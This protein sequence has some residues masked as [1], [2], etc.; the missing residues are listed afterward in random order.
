MRGLTTTVLL[1]LALAGLGAYIYFVESERPAGGVEEKEQVFEVE[2]D[3]IEEITV[4]TEGETTTLQKADDVW[5]LTAPVSADAD[6]TAASS[7][8][9]ALASLEVTRVVDENATNFAEYGLAEPRIALA[10]KA[11]DGAAG[12]LHLGDKNTTQSD[13]F[14]RRAG[15]NRVFLV[16]AWQETSLAKKTFDLRDKR[17][18]HFDR[19]QVDTVELQRAGSPTIVLARSGSEWNI[20]API[21]SRGD[22]S[23]VEGLLTRLS[24]GSMTE[25]VDPNGPETFGLD[26]PDAEIVVGTGSSRASLEFGNEADGNVYARDPARQLM[27]TVDARLLEDATKSVDEYRDKDVFEFRPFS[28]LRLRIAR[29][30]D[31][32]EF[33]KLTGAGENGT[34][35]WQ[36][37]VDD[38]ATDVDATKMDDLLSRLS[39]LRAQSFNPTT[40]AA[41]SAPST[42]VAVSY[43]S[44]TFERVR[45]IGGDGQAFAVREGE[46][47]VAV[48]DATA[49]DDAMKALDAIVAPS[50]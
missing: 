33:Q 26:E 14:A 16:P 7:L 11:Q 41:G 27:F 13:I 12:E 42:M 23:A 37:V 24:S 43:D 35:K 6:N 46:P 39:S 17:V 5:K 40:N 50:S 29:G 19:D 32:Y 20:E 1:V 2:A 45:L 25:L 44:G 9:T 34:D 10:F 49:Y 28:A 31:I 30:S 36:R 22:Y 15:E 3:Q 18:L 48:L 8:A 4:T 47:G 21:Q 38:N